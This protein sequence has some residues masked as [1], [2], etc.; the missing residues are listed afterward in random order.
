MWLYAEARLQPVLVIV[1]DL[2]WI[3]PST[4]ELL[5]LLIDQGASTRLCLVLTAR[6]EFR[7][8]WAMPAHLT[9]FTLRRFTPAQVTRLATHVAGDKALPPAV[10]EEVVRKTDGVPLFV[11][12]L[13][14]VVLES[15]LLQEREDRYDLTGLLP[16]LAIPATLHDALMARLDRLAAAKLVAQLGAAIGRAFTYDL[17]QAVAP[18][19]AATLQGALA[20]LVEA[21]LVA[22][23]GMPPQAT[24]TFKHA[25][26]QDAAYQSLLRS[27]RQQYHQRIA[28][29]LAERLPETAEMQ[30]ELLAH[31]YTEAG[32]HE[33]AIPY[34]QRA[35]RLACERSAN[36]ESIQHLTMGLKLLAA[37]PETPARAQQELDLQL[38]LGSALTATK[39][40]GAPETWHVYARARELCQQ[41]GETP[42]L[43]PMLAGLA[44]IYQNRGDLLTAHALGEQHFR[45]AQGTQDPALVMEARRTLGNILFWR[46]EL[47]SARAHLEAGLALYHPQQHG[48]HAVLYG[49]DPGM[50]FWGFAALTLWF[51]GYPDQAVA[52]T[53]EAL[54]LTQE[55]AHPYSLATALNFTAWLHQCRR[56]RPL[57]H[58]RAEAVLA[59]ATEHGIAQRWASSTVLL[60]WTLAEQGR[61]A[62]GI[63]QMRQGLAAW[64]ATGA[65]I[66]RPYFLA[67]LAEA[68]VQGGQVEEGLAVLAEAL[69]AVD[70]TEERLYEA[71]LYRLK[72]ELLLRQAV[73]VDLHPTSTAILIMAESDEGAT[74]R[75]PRL[76]EVEACFQQALAIARRQQ[77]KSLELR[78]ALSLSR[79]WQ[80]QGK[81]AEAYELLA[82][83]YGWFTEGFDTADLQEAKGL[84][85]ELA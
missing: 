15:G 51:L 4:L 33:Q 84:L 38:V 16:P 18:L 68:C 8:S 36:L 12:E 11:E 46:G 80:Q 74:G 52:S 54:R 30:P 14:K 39:G 23:R 34:W 17:L 83:I 56:E 53:Q 41:V 42:Q 9:L 70:K 49:R 81:R 64:Q 79:L 27:T 85:E 1:E 29:I 32:L 40:F 78:A 71:E 62:E 10:L 37:L 82:P 2:H 59:L 48:G 20:Q 58:E 47:A 31:H 66:W 7:P 22:Q 19:D 75:S 21:E 35:G 26:I 6:P 69:A 25:L 63:A 45:L 55:L 50:D 28:Q 13:T 43:F 24:Y 76:I 65:A 67:L 77:A 60:G 44:R 5:S 61:V 72:G 73:A 57:T 3:D